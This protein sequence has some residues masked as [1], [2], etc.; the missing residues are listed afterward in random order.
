MPTCIKCRKE[1]GDTPFCQY[2]GAKQQKSAPRRKRS[3]GEGTIYPRGKTWTA[4]IVTGYNDNGVPQLLRKGGFPTRSKAIEYVPVLKA[5]AKIP[6]DQRRSVLD[7]AVQM[8]T[9][10]EGIALIEMWTASNAPQAL[11]VKTLYER[12]LDFYEP[13][14]DKSTMSGHRAAFGHIKDLHGCNFADLT[15]DD[16]QECIDNCTRGRRTQE[17]IRQL[18]KR[19]YEF[20]IGRLIVSVNCA[21]YLYIPRGGSS[22]RAA[23]TKQHMDAIRGQ[24]GLRPFADYVYCLAYLGFRPNEMLMLK[25]DAY[26]VDNG[27]HYLIGGFKTPAG[28]DRVVTIPLRILPIIERLVAAPGEYI[29]P[30]PGG[31]QMTDAYLREKVFYPLLDHL[32]IQPIPEEGERAQYVPYSCRHFYSNLLKDAAGADKDKAALMGHADYDTTK[33]NYQSSDLEA[34]RRITDFF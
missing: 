23:L 25:K 30:A 21:E 28:T 6:K 3:N 10:A 22:P 20:A 24:I 31:G 26:H 14:V 8:A 12:W 29:F 17:N 4:Q 13:R 9:P 11:S 1:I 27:I 5:S 16:F 18:A 34:M 32:G 15:A 7:S 33:R 19:L 2:C